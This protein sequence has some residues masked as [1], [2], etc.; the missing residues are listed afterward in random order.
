MEGVASV[1]ALLDRY[2]ELSQKLGEEL[3]DGEMDKV[4]AEHGRVQ[5]EIEAT[6]GWELERTLDI[7]LDALRCPP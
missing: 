3:S 5:D 4:L 1:K 7:A 2:E 6:G